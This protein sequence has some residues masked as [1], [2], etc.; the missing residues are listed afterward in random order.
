MKSRK[1]DYTPIIRYLI[2]IFITECHFDYEGSQFHISK[3]KNRITVILTHLILSS[4]QVPLLK[5]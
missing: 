2:T 3:D 1:N 4:D 5:R